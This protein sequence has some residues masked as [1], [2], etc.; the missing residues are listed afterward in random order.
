MIKE[1]KQ[2][3]VYVDDDK[4]KINI[5]YVLLCA[6]ALALTGVSFYS[7]YLLGRKDGVRIAQAGIMNVVANGI[8]AEVNV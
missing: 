7:G 1:V 6:G 3:I 4:K 5:K 2:G 8:E